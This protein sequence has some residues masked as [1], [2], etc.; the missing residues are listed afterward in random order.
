MSKI[1]EKYWFM[2]EP[3]VGIQCWITDITLV[4]FKWK[5]YRI[6]AE[7][8]SYENFKNF[9]E[10]MNMDWLFKIKFLKNIK[11]NK[12]RVIKIIENIE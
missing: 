11:N 3:N 12:C 9:S 5:I 1:L 10:D 4:K 2:Y 7:F 8:S 6:I